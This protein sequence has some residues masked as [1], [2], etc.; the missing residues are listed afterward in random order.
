VTGN[1]FTYNVTGATLTPA[2][3]LSL[4]TPAAISRLGIPVGSSAITVDASDMASLVAA[5]NAMRA[6]IDY[7]GQSADYQ[8][9]ISF[10]GQVH[11]I[12][13][14][15]TKA[16]DPRPIPPAPPANYSISY[17]PGGPSV[18]GMPADATNLRTGDIHV[19]ASA[20]EREGYEFTGWRGSDGTI[21]QPG[22]SYT[23]A[24]ESLTLTAIWEG[25]AVVAVSSPVDTTITE[26]ETPLASA[27]SWAL[28]NL[29]I[30]IAGVLL[31]AALALSVA[32]RRRKDEQGS[33]ASDDD[34]RYARTKGL[35]MALLCVGIVIALA[36]IIIFVMTQDM[37]APMVWVDAWT[38]LMAVLFIIQIVALV[39]VL[40]KERVDDDDNSGM[41]P[42]PEGQMV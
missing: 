3:F 20:P 28:I 7:N 4:S 37:S 26:T 21:Y 19:I 16:A 2:I 12:T 36:N 6:R 39:V 40:R 15:L 11:L 22:D 41:R 33:E 34:E 14:T 9:R 17:L 29:L 18:T 10:D 32:L 8:V 27:S 31:A 5:Q 38:V 35:R 13:V 30:T 42:V 1:N 23:V 24:D 25:E